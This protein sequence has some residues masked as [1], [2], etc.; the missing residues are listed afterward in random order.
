[1]AGRSS[2]RSSA[3]IDIMRWDYFRPE[4][5]GGRRKEERSGRPTNESGALQL[6]DYSSSLRQAAGRYC[7]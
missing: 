1:M 2:C 5:G 7:L 6:I 4:G 3:K